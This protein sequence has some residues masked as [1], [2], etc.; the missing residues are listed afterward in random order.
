MTSERMHEAGAGA[1]SRAPQA[2][3]PVFKPDNSTSKE[4]WNHFFDVPK[5]L[6]VSGAGDFWLVGKRGVCWGAQ[7]Q[8]SRSRPDG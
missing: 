5:V 1:S 4:L 2:R 3:R 6:L 7:D 8:S